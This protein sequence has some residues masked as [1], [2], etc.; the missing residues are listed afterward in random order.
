VTKR[1]PHP[2]FTQALERCRSQPSATEERFFGETAFR[3][4]G[5]VFAFL[6]RPDRAAVTVKPPAEDVER[7]LRRPW[8]RRAAYVGRFGWL[9]VEICDDASLR[10]ALDLIDRSYLAA[11]APRR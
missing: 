10:F 1:E 3:V 2:W 11:S 8:V 4:R 7:L 5:R 6:G 9:T